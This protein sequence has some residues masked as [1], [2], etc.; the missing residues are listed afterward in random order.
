MLRFVRGGG[1]G[2]A[3]ETAMLI[4]DSRLLFDG[5]RLNPEDPTMLPEAGSLLIKP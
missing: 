4:D 5:A 2:A 3:F 1:E